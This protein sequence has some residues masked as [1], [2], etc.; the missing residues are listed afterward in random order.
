MVKRKNAQIKFFGRQAKSKRLGYQIVG[1]VFP[2]C[3]A[4]LPSH[5]DSHPLL[6]GPKAILNKGLHGDL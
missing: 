3:I 2:A 4:N 5:N 1:S 6:F